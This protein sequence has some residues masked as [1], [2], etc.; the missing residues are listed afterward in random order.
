VLEHIICTRLERAIDEAGGLSPN[1]F[2]FRKGKSTVVAIDKVVR[3]AAEAAEGSR[4]KGGKKEYCLIVTLDIKNAFNSVRWD[5]IIN[6]MRRLHIPPYLE[7]I[8]RCYFK[9]RLLTYD[10]A[11]GTRTYHV[12]AGVPQGSVMGPLLWNIVYD[13]V[14]R[15]TLPQGCQLTCYADDV[16]LTVVGKHLNAVENTCSVAVQVISNWLLT[17]GLELAANKT[18]AVLVSTRAVVEIAH[19]R[20]GAQ[21]ISSERAIGYLGVMIDTRLCFREHLSYVQEKAANTSRALVRIM[22]NTRG[23]RQERRILLTSVVRS[24]ITYAAAIWAEGIKKTSYAR[25]V[26]S[27]H[28]LCA[29][30]ICSGFRTISDEAALV[31]AGIIPIELLVA[32]EKSVADAI[33]A[34]TDKK[35]A[36]KTARDV[37]Y[38]EWQS[39]WDISEKGRWTYR[40]IPDIKRWLH[41][42]HG[43]VNFYTT[44][45]LTGHGCL[46]QY[47]N[48]FGHEGSPLC[49]WCENATEDAEHIIFVCGRFDSLRTNLWQSAG[50]VLTPSS[51]VDTMLSDAVFW[52]AFNNFA[53]VTMKELRRCERLRR[54]A[55]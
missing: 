29:L 49:R 22:L 30:R 4:W 45:L 5:S 43:T 53:A 11:S 21:I 31:L 47:L 1:Q 44:Q 48:R 23:P 19:I 42:K 38:R 15:L 16:A 10:T 18:E 36:R 17:V 25:G 3:I 27:I 12:S 20:V 32:E 46:A 33:R 24:V 8:I 7:E 28:R 41:R 40:L 55:V 13:G 6:A 35:E 39:R 52:T 54:E 34:G 26:K 51:L 9:G 37:S 50:R 14:M 2:G